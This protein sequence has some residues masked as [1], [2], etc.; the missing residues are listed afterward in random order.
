LLADAI[1]DGIQG[2]LVIR[3]DEKG[4]TWANPLHAVKLL[5]D[6]M[7]KAKELRVLWNP[8]NPWHRFALETTRRAGRSLV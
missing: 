1:F 2:K 5:Q 7:L 8:H 4:V 3:S 6:Y